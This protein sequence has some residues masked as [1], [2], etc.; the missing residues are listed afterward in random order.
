[1]TVATRPASAAALRCR[2]MHLA[3]FAQIARRCR[4]RFDK[5]ATSKQC[6]EGQQVEDGMKY[7]KEMHRSGQYDVVTLHAADRRDM[8]DGRRSRPRV[9]LLWWALLGIVPWLVIAAILYR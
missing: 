7:D 3:S 4:Q 8:G 2:P 9:A 5:K 1:M 6:D